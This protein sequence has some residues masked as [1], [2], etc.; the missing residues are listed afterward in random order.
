M[1]FLAEKKVGVGGFGVTT[2][3]G[4]IQESGGGGKLAE[5]NLK[6]KGKLVVCQSNRLWPKR[7]FRQQG[8]TSHSPREYRKE[9]RPH[10]RLQVASAQSLFGK[11][12][13][14]DDAPSEVSQKGRGLDVG[15]SAKKMKKSNPWQALH[16]GISQTRTTLL[17]LLLQHANRKACRS[18]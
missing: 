4:S 2:A 12:E 16:V 14:D 1:R 8:R 15:A 18:D 11:S 6:K 10:Y 7:R 13:P 3:E 17:G 5:P 9:G